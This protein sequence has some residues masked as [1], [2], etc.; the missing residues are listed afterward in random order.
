[1][2]E[3]CP[4]QSQRHSHWSEHL[5]CQDNDGSYDFTEGGLIA[6]RVRAAV[7]FAASESRSADGDASVVVNSAD[8]VALVMEGD[9]VAITAVLEVLKRLSSCSSPE[10]QHTKSLATKAS[11]HFRGQQ[12]ALIERAQ[13]MHPT[14]VEDASMT[15]PGRPAKSEPVRSDD[16]SRSTSR[17]ATADATTT[18]KRPRPANKPAKHTSKP[19]TA[20]NSAAKC[21]IVRPGAQ[22]QDSQGLHVFRM[23][24]PVAKP[25]VPKQTERYD[26][27][28]CDGLVTRVCLWMDVELGIDLPI[29]RFLSKEVQGSNCMSQTHEMFKDGVLLSRIAAEVLH[30]MCSD[31][32]IVA[33]ADAADPASRSSKVSRSQSRRNILVARDLFERLGVSNSSLRAVD[34]LRSGKPLQD[35][36]VLI[37]KALDELRLNVAP[38]KLYGRGAHHIYNSRRQDEVAINKDSKASKRVE[39]PLKD[40]RS[41]PRRISVRQTKLMEEWVASLGLNT[42]VRITEQTTMVCDAVHLSNASFVS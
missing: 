23:L 6:R 26:D 42:H 7:R 21:A 28:Y 36:A 17:A 14:I 34:R 5:E 18:G 1:M 11:I 37:W 35:D 15:Q 10:R 9:Y 2:R 24:D 32:G 16:K 38:R 30:R 40:K 27:G 25:K 3:L 22:Y 19:R 31:E 39:G 33:K 12:A 29:K 41:A 20:P 13:S 8:C 4:L